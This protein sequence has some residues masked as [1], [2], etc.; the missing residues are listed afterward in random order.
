MTPP[1]LEGPQQPCG[2]L[3]GPNHG[4]GPVPVIWHRLQEV[5]G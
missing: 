2:L 1:L 4:L 5:V 3:R